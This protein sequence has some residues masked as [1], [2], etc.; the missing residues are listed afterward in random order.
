MRLRRLS[1]EAVYFARLDELADCLESASLV[2]AEL[3]GIPVDQR[4]SAGERLSVLCD[5]ADEASAALVRQLRENYATPLEREDLYRLADALRETCHRLDGVGFALSSSA[6]DEFP[7]GVLEMLA[8]LA[9]AS[10]ATKKALK[11]M[12]A[13]PDQWEYVESVTRLHYRAQTLQLKVSDAVPA[14]KR[15]LVYLA[16]ASQLGTAFLAAAESFRDV[17]AA[18]ADI[19]VKES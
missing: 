8:L 11:R 13:Q 17:G 3:S 1:R 9:N 15:G 12:P 7:A 4:R 2:L 14:A 5:R 19:A 6:F 16:A 18:A 10:D